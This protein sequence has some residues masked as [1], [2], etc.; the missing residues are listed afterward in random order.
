MK[1]SVRDESLHSRMG[2]QLFRHMCEEY[3]ELQEQCK[4]SIEQ[5][6]LIVELETKFIDKMFEMERFRKFKS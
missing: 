2:C 3:P 1:W 6:K 5:A 4:D